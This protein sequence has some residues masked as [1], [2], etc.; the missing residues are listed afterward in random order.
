M[1]PATRARSLAF[2]LLLVLAPALA[3]AHPEGGDPQTGS[4]QKCT[5]AVY[6]SW[7]KVSKAAG[8]DVEACL[9]NYGKG[10][11]LTPNP[12]VTTLEICVGFD[13]KGKIQKAKG[14]TG[15]TFDKSCGGPQRDAIDAAGFPVFPVYGVSTVAT[16]NAAGE[17]QEYDLAHD[18]FG[19]DLDAGAL[20][21]ESDPG[22]GKDAAK[23]QQRV[24]K[25]AGKCMQ[26][27]QKQFLKCVKT[28]LKSGGV[29]GLIYDPDDLALCL[30][31]LD[32]F[33]IQKKCDG[34]PGQGIAKDVQKKC[35][36]KVDDRPLSALFPACGSDDVATVGTC[37]AE[38]VACRF[39]LSATAAADTERDCDLFDDGDTDNNSCLPCA[40]AVGYDSTFEAIQRIIFESPVY[41]CSSGLCH[42]SVAPQ[43][44][45]ALS[46]DPNTPAI[47]SYAALVNEPGSG[48]SPPADRV[49]PGEPALSFL[50]NKLAAATL[51]GHDAGGGSPMPSGGAPA[52]TEEHLEAVEKWIRGGAPE[53]LSVE[54]TALLLGSCLPDPDPLTI[55]PPDA[56]GAGV[57]VQLRQTPWPLPAEFE[58][59]ICMATYYDLT[60]TGL[61]P[62][63][64][65][66]DCPKQFLPGRCTGGANAEEGC[67]I[68]ADCPDQGVGTA[69]DPTKGM[70][71]NPSGLCFAYNSQVLTQDPQSHHSIIHIYTG[72]FD[73]G[74]PGWGPFT[75]KFQDAGNPNQGMSCDPTAVDATG[76]N[77]GCSGEVETA[78]ACL[79]YG[80]PD[81]SFG[82][83][84]GIGGANAPQFS[85]SQE[86]YF[87]QVYPSGVYNVLP[88]QGVI[89]WN[90]HAF[91]LTSGDS[92]LSQYLNLHFALGASEQQFP[93]QGIFDAASIFVQDVP[94]FETREYCRT[95]TLPPNAA[96]FEL[97]SHTHR[98]GTLWRT[99]APPN[100][101]CTPGQPACVARVDTPI[102]VSVEYTDPLQL[103]FDPPILHGTDFTAPAIAARTY[104]YCSRYDNG[105]TPASPAVKR[106]ST[107]PSPPVALPFGGPCPDIDLQCI[108][109]PNQ[110]TD[111]FYP[112][113]FLGTCESFPG[114]GDGDCDACPVKG[115]VTTE[116]EMFILL[117][118]YYIP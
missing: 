36:D 90:S 58:N 17:S 96:L 105:A 45:L 115:G 40:A 95:Y 19:P 20:A 112:D 92:T 35:A 57:G 67:T 18:L 76:A 63:P 5:N 117:G 16:V 69:C 59:E 28:H 26:E 11:P 64:A 72:G 32:T 21:K 37:V 1:R 75:Y 3:A 111:C 60:N 99:W 7:S 42:G 97:G 68:L 108:G 4:Q 94:P 38:R 48:A 39:C 79:G 114:A 83:G 100:T 47:E 41:G 52:L 10:K 24:V 9:K 14:K 104:L 87:Q 85:G 22:D 23:C 30:D 81:Y 73:T 8:K 43:G 77:P 27:R 110:G 86:P 78:V 80:P 91:N 66:V 15:D 89:V 53:E 65:M 54:G 2:A 71:N 103:T 50:Y 46:D 44:G 25:A 70:K 84:L 107:S 102:Y 55:P 56:P 74:D 49:E 113:D 82:G 61:V 93:V 98:H 13:G 88:M 34:V 62:G 29:Y 106:Q 109:G 12:G 51:P 101:P 118:N 6:K 33:K 116:D 31:G